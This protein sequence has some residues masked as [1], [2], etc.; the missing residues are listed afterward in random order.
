MFV[1]YLEIALGSQAELE[2]QLEIPAGVDS[3]LHLTMMELP[4]T[5]HQPPTTTP[6]ISAVSYRQD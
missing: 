6:D 5:Y 4:T 1:S 3:S 2:V